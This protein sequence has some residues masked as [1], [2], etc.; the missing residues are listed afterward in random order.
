MGLKI[1]HSADWHLD[2]PFQGFRPEQ[3]AYLKRELRKIPGKITDLCI[4]E[5]CDLMLL[6]GDIFDGP[7]TRESVEA[8]YS[9]LERC[10]VPVFIS[11]GNHDFLA[12]GSPW[13]EE[14]WPD[15]VHIFPAGLS[16]VSLPELDCRIYGAGY[17]S[18]ECEGLLEGFRAEGPER[19]RLAVLHGDPLRLHSPYCP[20][21]AAQVRDS[22]LSYLA[23]GHIHKAGSFR[24]RDTLCGWPGT[25]MGRG[26]DETREKGV[27]IIEIDSNVA[28]RQVLLDT[29]RFYTPEVDTDEMNLDQVLPAAE[30]S[31]FYR[32][33][34]LGSG[35]ES[36]RELRNLY[37]RFPNLEFI[38]RR[39]KP[40]DPWTRAGSD[41]LEGLYFQLL[42]QKLDAAPEEEKAVIAL[43]AEI[44]Q[45][46]LDGREVTL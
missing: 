27:Y 5:N 39:Q 34:L 1:L 16:S 30:D 25:P 4:R 26:F 38:D 19:C 43:A 6:S 24:A 2:S 31:H 14:I 12:P 7:Y 17:R 28:L 40:I 32:I 35:E 9:A 15:N 46:I 20:I 18:M 23:L 29:P 11:P 8:A 41:S 37:A 21:T 13:L 36:L 10:G 44:S 45:K 3:Q 33:T 42:R 22:G